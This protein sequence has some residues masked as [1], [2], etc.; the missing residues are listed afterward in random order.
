MKKGISLP[1][2]LKWAIIVLMLYS[3]WK[4]V[5]SDSEHF[6]GG[7]STTTTT[8]TTVESF[9]PAPSASGTAKSTEPTCGGAT[10]EQPT[11]GGKGGC[12]SATGSKLLPV[13]DPCFNMREICKQCILLEDHLFQNEKRCTDCIKKHFL[14]IEGLAEEAITLDKKNEYHLSK[15]EL[16]EKVRGLQRKFINGQ[17]PESIAQELRWIRKPLM[18]DFFHK[19]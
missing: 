11:C 18:A 12:V 4:C 17:D 15:L 3:I 16:P 5:K 14:T 19:F 9:V 13:L 2:L 7:S 6:R 8:N 10:A 1:E